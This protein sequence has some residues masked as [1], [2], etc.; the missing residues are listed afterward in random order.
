MTVMAI[1]IIEAVLDEHVWTSP[2]NA[3]QLVKSLSQALQGLLPLEGNRKAVAERKRHIWPNWRTWTRYTEV[4]AQGARKT[5]LW[6][7]VSFRYL[8]D[9]YH[10]SYDAA[11][12]GCSEDSEPSAQTLA[13]LIGEIRSQNIPWC[14]ILSFPAARPRKFWRRKPGPSPCCSPPATMCARRRWTPEPP[15]CP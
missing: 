5:D 9:A 1:K 2:K 3:I 7:P 15:I 11:F 13:S 14:F 12:P 4:A 8:V 6:G 10:L